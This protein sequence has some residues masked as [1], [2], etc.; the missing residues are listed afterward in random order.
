MF[1]R[2]LP[3][4]LLLHYYLAHHTS[5]NISIQ[6]LITTQSNNN[7]AQKLLVIN[8]LEKDAELPII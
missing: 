7:S 1:L 8:G 6:H 4:S 5:V 2:I 3:A